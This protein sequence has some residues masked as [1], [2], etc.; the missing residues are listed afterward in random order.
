MAGSDRKG[1]GDL[2]FTLQLQTLH[3]NRINGVITLDDDEWG[4]FIAPT[5]STPKALQFNLSNGF[6]HLQSSLSPPQNSMNFDPFG[7]FQNNSAK[8]TQSSAALVDSDSKRFEKPKGPLPLSIFGEEEEESPVDDSNDFF[9]PAEDVKN[10]VKFG[11]E[12][13]VS[14]IIVK[15]YNQD[16]QI[17]SGNGSSLN[18]DSSGSI[19]RPDLELDMR[20]EEVDDEDDWEFMGAF[21]ENGGGERNPKGQGGSEL[22]GSIVEHNTVQKKQDTFRAVENKPGFNQSSRE[23][24]YLFS[25]SNGFVDTSSG[26]KFGLKFEPTAIIPNGFISI[27]LPEAE[28]VGKVGGINSSSINDN[29]YFDE[30]GDFMGASS[31]IVYKHQEQQMVAPPN[32]AEANLPNGKVQ[33]EKMVDPSDTSAES[34]LHNGKFEN[35][36]TTPENGKGPL[37]LSLFSDEMVDS[38]YNHQDVFIYKPASDHRNGIINQDSGRS[39]HDL[40]S[41]L[42]SQAHHNSH[43][44]HTSSVDSD[45]NRAGNGLHSSKML[46]SSSV[47]SD[48]DFDGGSWEFKDAFLETRVSECFSSPNLGDVTQGLSAKSSDLQAYLDFYTKLRDELCL[49]LSGLLD[50]S[51][52]LGAAVDKDAKAGSL[53]KEIQEAYKVMQD[54]R[55]SIEICSNEQLPRKI[56]LNEILEVLHEPKFQIIELEYLLSRRLQLAENDRRN[57]IELLEHCQSVLKI[58]TL[59]SVKEQSVYISTWSRV[60]VFGAQELRHGALIWKQALEKNVHAQIL[61]DQRGQHYIRALGEI[62]RVVELL[63]ISAKLYKPWILFSMGNPKAIFPLLDECAALWLH[64]GLQEALKMLAGM[65]NSECS[66]PVKRLLESIK[67]IH[68]IDLP[69]VHNID[70]TLQGSIC[71]LSLLPQET[72]PGLKMVSWNDKHYFL[73]LAN[74]W[75]NLISCDP[76]ELPHL[77]VG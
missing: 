38:D 59:G 1:F 43:T 56:C 36:M 69:S 54:S 12:I 27:P 60:I 70:L 77:Q 11:S 66:E 65:L 20:G 48:D 46:D 34:H 17:K 53:D 10:E 74:L 6:S 23:F 2:Q 25:A 72:L 75:A 33:E 39:I 16:K 45:K 8:P 51:K 13:A 18:L 71:R 31:D 14:E 3:A 42:Y 50:D 76:P 15:L 37:P 29:D 52:S 4:D 62:Y 26:M 55:G 57:A 5:Q 67:Y 41:T 68:N 58:L 47:N 9:G 35:N 32:T 19:S 61:S 24:G 28:E 49:I 64:S 7:F 73:N 40:I 30:F 22:S 44:E 63:G 21:S